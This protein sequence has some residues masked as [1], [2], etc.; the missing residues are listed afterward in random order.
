MTILVTGSSGFVAQSLIPKLEKLG[1]DVIG[2]DWK[3]GEH[4]KIIHDISKSLEIE[5]DKNY[6]KKIMKLKMILT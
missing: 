2:L 6:L 4:T 1:F 3:N 5:E